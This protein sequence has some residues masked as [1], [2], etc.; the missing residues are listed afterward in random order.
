MRLRS[1]AGSLKPMPPSQF[2]GGSKAVTLEQKAA[3]I[4]Y[5]RDGDVYVVIHESD[6]LTEINVPSSVDVATLIHNDDF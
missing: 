6:I 4:K 3:R 2:G 1:R 5:Q